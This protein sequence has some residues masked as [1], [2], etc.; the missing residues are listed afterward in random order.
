MTSTTTAAPTRVARRAR[1]AVSAL[2][3][4]NGALF[5]NILPRYPEIKDVLGLDNGTYG[6]TIIAF[7]AGAIAAGLAAGALVRWAGSGRLAVAGTIVTALGLLAA[8]LAPSVPLFVVALLVGGA[9][10]SITDVAQNAHGM[11]VQREYGK[12]IL[13]SFHAIWSVGAVTGGGM[14]AAAIALGIPLGIHLS[15]SALVFVVIAAIALRLTLPG[16]DPES[17]VI[18][19]ADSGAVSVVRRGSNPRIVLMLVALVFVAIAGTLVEDA[20]FSW[21][22]LYLGDDLGAAPAIA[23]TGLVAL[24]AAQFVGRLAGDPLVDRF[25]QRAVARVGGV[26]IALGMGTALL[27]PSVPGTIAGFAAAGLGVATLVPAAMAAADELPGLRRGTGIAIVSWLMR[28]GFLAS[29]PVIG[30]LSETAGLQAALLVIP[31]AGLIAL[32]LSF[33]LPRATSS[34]AS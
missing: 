16:R 33:A 15:I 29:P 5:A 18:A 19:P 27:F 11:R 6:L 12:S 26:I 20:G 28:L 7:P 30:A 23:A 17:D 3:F 4:T 24:V 14:A 13:N 2:F 9:A 1:L 22:A 8:G 21:A 10:D 34:K 31:A 32:A 25:G